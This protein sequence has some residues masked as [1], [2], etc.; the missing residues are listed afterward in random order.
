M[1]KSFLAASLLLLT[2]IAAN[3]QGE[4][5]PAIDP[6]AVEIAGA[7]FKFVAEQPHLSVSWFV[8]YDRVFEGREKLTFV[9]TGTNTLV[10]GKGFRSYAEHLNKVREY[11][12]DGE[13][14]TVS[15]P[16]D[17]F[18]AQAEVTGSFDELVDGLSEK[19]DLVLPIWQLLSAESGELFF[20]EV[21]R[22]TYMGTT[23]INGR[24]AH[25]LAFSEYDEDFQLWIAADE[26][27]PLPLMIVGT[28]PYTQGWPQYHAYM[29]DWNLE[30]EIADDTF[31]FTPAEGE[32][33]IGFETLKV[34]PESGEP[35]PDTKE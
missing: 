12:Y 15:A 30:P 9:R 35:A 8:T 11:I 4:E 23:L 17:G 2:P 3:A 20:E 32:A 6:K 10:R 14:F 25:H 24:A 21:E 18:Y 28:N 13:T 34:D 22:A 19:Y 31:A 1:I 27:R 5:P 7:A 16:L 33:Q 29:Y 26:E